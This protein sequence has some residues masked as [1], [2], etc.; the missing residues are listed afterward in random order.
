MGISFNNNNLGKLTTSKANTT[1]KTTNQNTTAKAAS[2]NAPKTNSLNS[3]TL[4]NKGQVLDSNNF[5]KTDVIPG[6]NKPLT[7]NAEEA[8]DSSEK[9]G[10]WQRLKDNLKEAFSE[11]DVHHM[12]NDTSDN[13]IGAGLTA[14]WGFGS[15]VVK[16][17]KES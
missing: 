8:S 6:N 14:L 17:I 13:G 16:T 7:K 5:G 12:E 4:T 1:A 11:Q 10:F 3:E 15:A 9:K 2:N